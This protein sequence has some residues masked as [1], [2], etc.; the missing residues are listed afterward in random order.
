MANIVPLEPKEQLEMAGQAVFPDLGDICSGI[1][2]SSGIVSELTG[3]LVVLSM[4]TN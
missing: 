4:A 1:G 2:N 3:I